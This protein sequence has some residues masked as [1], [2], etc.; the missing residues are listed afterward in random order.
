M[1]TTGCYW[2]K[3]VL[4]V[5]AFVAVILIGAE[6]FSTYRSVFNL[7]VYGMV[8]LGGL[9]LLVSWHART[10][11]YRCAECGHEFEIPAWKDLV[12]PHGVNKNG[13]WKYLRCP[14]CGHW[15]KARIIPKEHIHENMK[16]I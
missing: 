15:M 4:Y 9:F 11:A 12:S 6:I 14:G 10:F 8:A 5:L 1:K 7:I 13:G 2:R 3:S 16:E